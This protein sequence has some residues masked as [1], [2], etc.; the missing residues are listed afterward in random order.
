M[1]LYLEDEGFELIEKENGA[2]ALEYAENHRVDLV[3]LDILMPQMDGWVLCQ[4]LREFGEMPIL[5]VTAKGEATDR[6][7]GF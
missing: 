3:I 6:I 7:K 5:M 2:E 1:R 4:K